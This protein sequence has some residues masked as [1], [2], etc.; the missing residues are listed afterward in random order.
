MEP[1]PVFPHDCRSPRRCSSWISQ[2]LPRLAL[3][4][5]PAAGAA[6]AAASRAPLRVNIPRWCG[7]WVVGMD[8]FANDVSGGKFG[9]GFGGF[10]PGLCT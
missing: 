10:K 1:R 6:A 4:W 5:L 2:L 8:G 3:A 7:K 9:G